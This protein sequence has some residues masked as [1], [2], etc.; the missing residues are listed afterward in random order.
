MPDLLWDDVKSF[1][2]PELMGSLPDVRVPDTSVEDWQA[3]LDLVRSQGWSCEYS[4]DGAVARLPRAA[5]MLA[6]GEG[7]DVVLRVWPVSGFLVIFRPYEAGSIDF[8]V[9]LR[10]LQGQHGVNV[11]C[12]LLRV[13]GRRLG[14]PV[15]LSPES[16][17]LHPVLGFGVEAD[18]VVLLAGP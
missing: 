6:R 17:P 2:A 1:F 18:R 13:V 7:A 10:E 9:D 14:K 16:D 12:R 5:E 3:V 11:L 4:E 15:L 8:D